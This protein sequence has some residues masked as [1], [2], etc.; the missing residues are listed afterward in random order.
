[1]FVIASA[2]RRSAFRFVSQLSADRIYALQQIVIL[3]IAKNL[4]EEHQILHCVQDDKCSSSRA[5][6]GDLPFDLFLSL[7]LIV[8][9][10]CSR[11]SF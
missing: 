1:M 8:F 6:R 9:A 3:S 11:L 10:L 5:Q 4:A 2:A 7:A